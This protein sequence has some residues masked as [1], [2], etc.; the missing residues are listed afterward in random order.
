MLPLTLYTPKPEQALKQ[1]PETRPAVTAEWLEQ[2]SGKNPEDAAQRLLAELGRLNRTELEEDIR[3]RLT[4]LYGPVVLQLIEA[5]LAALPDN[6]TPQSAAHR[7]SANLAYELAIELSYAWKL[8]SLAVQ[9]KR[10]LFGGTK[11]KQTALSHLLAALSGQICTSY[12][13]YTS[14]PIHSW[15]ELHQLYA[16]I[17]EE[18]HSDTATGSD[19][20]S[21]EAIYK[22]T[23]LLAL[24]DPFR[25]TRPEIEVTLAYLE[26][27]GHLAELSRGS[28]GGKSVFLINPESDSPAIQDEGKDTPAALML[29]THALCK[30]LRSLL[31]KLQGG[32]AF[33]DI[34]LTD[35]PHKING[36]H[37]LSRLHQTWRGTNKRSFKRYEP[38]L[39]H[40]EVISGIPAIHRLFDM[41]QKTA[42]ATSPVPKTAANG[43]ADQSAPVR[44]R[45]VNDSANG[46][47]ISAHAQEVAQVRMGNPIALREENTEGAAW[48]LGVIRWGKMSKG[49]VVVAGVEKLSPDVASVVLRFAEGTA[50]NFGQPALLIPANPVLQT[51]ERL[52][53]PQGLYQRGRTADLWHK[54]ERRRVGLG[55][56]VE[57]TPFFDLVEVEPA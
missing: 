21:A 40:V 56:L 27:F 33:R 24:A 54:G 10:S 48:L 51:D 5:L 16:A 11:A 6:G 1:A 23:L 17:S 46:I 41:K 12:R 29:D 42:A 47:S 8:V 31:V 35:M 7:Q 13:S 50:A 45:V 26:K 38:G 4:L 15:H 18:G 9:Q 52:L 37:L 55:S 22:R 36:P 43:L 30:H 20:Q 39:T 53:L 2:L 44:W 19:S 57:Q 25:F 49:Q 14:P 32:E 34:G 28:K 3:S